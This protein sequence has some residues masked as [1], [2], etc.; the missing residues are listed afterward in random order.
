MF[1]PP[2]LKRLAR[3]LQHHK[4]LDLRDGP[5]CP[6]SGH[7]YPPP[8]IARSTRDQLSARSRSPCS[9]DF[10]LCFT[11][12]AENM[13]FCRR[14]SSDAGGTGPGFFHL[15]AEW[16]AECCASRGRTACAGDI[17]TFFRAMTRPLDSGALTD[18]T[19]TTNWQPSG[20]GRAGPCST[21][22]IRRVN[23]RSTRWTRRN[24]RRYPLG[25]PAPGA[26]RDRGGAAN[27]RASRQDQTRWRLKGLQESEAVRPAGL[28]CSARHGH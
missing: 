25:P 9:F 17:M 20:E 14:R 26:R 11:G 13:T 2:K 18:W 16:R 15:R 10:R 22:G 21:A 28:V 3:G 8:L 12:M 1:Q 27:G 24:L 6:K 19:L 23:V 4:G 5:G 7:G